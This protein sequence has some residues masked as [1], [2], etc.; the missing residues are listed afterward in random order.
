[1]WYA[2]SRCVSPSG[3]AASGGLD[4]VA[5]GEYVDD[6]GTRAKQ[7]DRGCGTLPPRPTLVLRRSHV[8][9]SFHNGF[10]HRQRRYHTIIVVFVVARLISGAARDGDGDG[11]GGRKGG[12]WERPPS[13]FHVH[14]HRGGWGWRWFAKISFVV[15]VSRRGSRF[16]RCCCW[17]GCRRR[18]GARAR[19]G[20][21]ATGADDGKGQGERQRGGRVPTGAHRGHGGV[22]SKIL[23]FSVC[24]FVVR[25]GGGENKF[26][27]VR[28]EVDSQIHAHGC[29]AVDAFSMRAFVD[30][31]VQTSSQRTH[32]TDIHIDENK[33]KKTHKRE[34]RK[35]KA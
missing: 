14:L 22:A 2:A 18:S 20:S 8:D 35:K 16:S 9:G 33:K 31:D 29:A 3:S 17:K 30:L 1:M 21:R 11:V 34:K 28:V 24:F 23:T 4:G 26:G 13:T 32:L 6:Y 7:R 10:P 12:T 5:A 25:G 15:I 27:V 19:R